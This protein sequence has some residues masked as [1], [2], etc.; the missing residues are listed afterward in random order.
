MLTNCARR[1][2]SIRAQS[3]GEYILYQRKRASI[4]L[5]PKVEMDRRLIFLVIGSTQKQIYWLMRPKKILPQNKNI[6]KVYISEKF[7]KTEI[8]MLGQRCAY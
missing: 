8:Y 3:N 1:G 7:E 6:S 2:G 5:F 4:P